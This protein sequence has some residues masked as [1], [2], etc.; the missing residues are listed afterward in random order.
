MCNVKTFSPYY[1]VC[2]FWISE[3]C[4]LFILHLYGALMKLS[5]CSLDDGFDEK[6]LQLVYDQLLYIY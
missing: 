2:S 6:F 3:I 4:L 5:K 1:P